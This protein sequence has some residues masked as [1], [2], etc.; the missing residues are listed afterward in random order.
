MLNIIKHNS[1][2][3]KEVSF[4]F[5]GRKYCI[6]KLPKVLFYTGKLIVIP[7]FLRVKQKDYICKIEMIINFPT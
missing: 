7:V 3:K 5:P 2:L 6:K 1:N 4:I